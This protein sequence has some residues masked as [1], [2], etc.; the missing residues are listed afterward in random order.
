MLVCPAELIETEKALRMEEAADALDNIR[1]L[2]V[3]ESVEKINKIRYGSG[4]SQRNMTRSMRLLQNIARLRD[5]QVRRYNIMREGLLRLDEN[6]D[7]QKTFKILQKSNLKTPYKDKSK[8]EMKAQDYRRKATKELELD[9]LWIWSMPGAGEIDEGSLISERY[10]KAMRAEWAK[11][12]A[13]LKRWNEEVILVKEEMRRVLAYMEWK[14]SKWLR[15][16]YVIGRSDKEQGAVAY[17]NKQASI[18]AKMS[19]NFR[20]MWSP[21]V[22]ED[23]L[24]APFHPPLIEFPTL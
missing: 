5:D 20:R 17:A 12:R 4:T 7:W 15:D 6:G 19:A 9:E 2:L 8:E 10:N 23:Q 14:A 24:P 1:K 13:R 3:Q 16:A 18:L 11:S 22:E 21:L